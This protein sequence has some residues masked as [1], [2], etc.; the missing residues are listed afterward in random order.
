[1]SPTKEGFW[2]PTRQKLLQTL[3]ALP[4][5]GREAYHLFY[6]SQA[7]QQWEQVLAH[8]GG[9]GRRHGRAI[10]EVRRSLFHQ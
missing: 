7:K 5:E 8:E 2:V 1:M 4:P 10:A 3:L 6:D 9:R